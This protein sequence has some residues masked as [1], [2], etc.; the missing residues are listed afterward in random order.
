MKLMQHFLHCYVWCYF[1]VWG[2]HICVTTAACITV[3][4]L[5]EPGLREP[6]LCD[7][8]GLY[9]CDFCHWNDTMVIPARILAN[10][11]FE[12]HKVFFSVF[13]CNSSFLWR[14]YSLIRKDSE[15]PACVV[16]NLASVE[17]LSGLHA[18]SVISLVWR[19]DGCMPSVPRHWQLS[20]I[21]CKFN[22]C[23]HIDHLRFW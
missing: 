15:W 23:L 4:C 14:D 7:F 9:Y 3:D 20:L 18:L 12:P 5:S 1:I 16:C 22:R 11:D 17:A 2:S 10:W 19:P 21:P 6:R 13:H 8:S